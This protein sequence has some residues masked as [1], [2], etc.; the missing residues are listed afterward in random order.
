M[1]KIKFYI[2]FS[3][4]VSLFFTILSP[5]ST[6]Y[7]SVEEAECLPAVLMLR[8]SGEGVVEGEYFQDGQQIFTT[9]PENNRGWE[10]ETIERLLTAFAAQTDVDETTSKVRFIG[11][12][13]TALGLAPVRL[14]DK[15]PGVATQESKATDAIR[16][17]DH[18]IRY[19]D[20]YLDGAEKIMEIIKSD[21]ERPNGESCVTNYMLVGYSQGVISLRL[22]LG[23]YGLSDKITSTYVIGDPVQKANGATSDRQM[24]IANTSPETDGVVRRGIDILQ[25]VP[26]L[27]GLD[28][29]RSIYTSGDEM[30]YQDNGEGGA[31][32]RSLCHEYDPT[33]GIKWGANGDE[34]G[35]YFQADTTPEP[36]ESLAGNVDLLSEI[37]EFD[38]QIRRLANQPTYT[39][40]PRELKHSMAIQGQEVMYTLANARGADKCW[41]DENSDGVI[42]KSD[43]S[44]LDPYK[45]QIS[46]ATAS[47]TVEVVDSFGGEYVFTNVTPTIDP[48]EVKHLGSLN[49]N[50]WYQLHPYGQPNS[51]LTGVHDKNELLTV[52]SEPSIAPCET[53][54]PSGLEQTIETSKQSFKATKYPYAFPTT[55]EGEITWGYDRDWRLEAGYEVRETYENGYYQHLPGPNHGKISIQKYSSYD[56]LEIRLAKIENGIPYYSIAKDNLCAFYD[57]SQELR[58]DLWVTEDSAGSLCS[59]SNDQL[60]SVTKVNAQMGGLS[61]EQD[62]VHPT[63]VTG[64]VASEIHK[65]SVTL[66]WDPASDIRDP[67]V[68]YN[69]YDSDF[70]S[71]YPII[72]KY[73]GTSVAVNRTNAGIEGT[74]YTVRAVDVG[75]NE[76]LG[77]EITLGEPPPAPVIPKPNTPTLGNLAEDYISVTINFPYTTERPVSSV[78]IYKN[79]VFY[80]STSEN[81]ITD[82]DIER[83]NVYEYTYETVDNYGDVSER[84]DILWVSTIND[85]PPSPPSNLAGTVNSAGTE[86]RISFIPGMDDMGDDLIYILYRNGVEIPSTNV[87]NNEI[88]DN[89]AVPG[90]NTYTIVAKDLDGN[91]SIHSEPLEV[92]MVLPDTQAPKKPVLNVT[93]VTNTSVYITIEST[94]NVSTPHFSIYRDGILIQSTDQSLIFD[95]LEPDTTYEYT[96][97]AVDDVGNVSEISDILTVT[98]LDGDTEAPTKPQLTLTETTEST[99]RFSI[100]STDNQAT[101]YY[102]VYRD[103]V[104]VKNVYSNSFYQSGLDAATTYE[105]TV[106][107]KDYN[108]NSSETSDVLTVTTNIPEPVDTEAPSKPIL[109]VG[110]L[111]EYSVSIN[112]ESTDNV[113]IDA[114]HIYR[115]GS[116]QTT[117]Y[118]STYTDNSLYPG[119]SYT[120]EVVAQD[121]SWNSSEMSDSL[122]VTAPAPTVQLPQVENLQN[123]FTAHNVVYFSWSVNEPWKVS[124]YDVYRDGVLIASNVYETSYIDRTVSADTEYSYTIIGKDW[125]NN[126][127]DMSQP[128]VAETLPTPTGTDTLAPSSFEFRYPSYYNDIVY[129]SWTE[130]VDDSSDVTYEV[131]RDGVLLTELENTLFYNN[132]SVSPET[133]YKYSVIAVDAAGNETTIATPCTVLTVNPGGMG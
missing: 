28:A 96:V 111:S 57:S 88:V 110:S 84:S 19:N 6:V 121:M 125:N 132:S 11:V 112:I 97:T 133:S 13:Y 32:S 51:C 9:G 87:S 126:Q 113:G 90:L 79:N 94:D 130:A 99:V 4:V 1:K 68:K 103:G 71:I 123:K 55:P 56:H 104:F 116:Y 74:T 29:L 23:L 14:I 86:V 77:A 21:L 61:L 52:P 114:Y 82:N 7:A 122:T 2:V 25:S 76:G 10:G 15:T 40:A 27:L 115:D 8:G 58:F 20:S 18:I 119:T 26:N 105:Y 59:G 127:T 60:F 62:T 78:N 108:G 42:E 45:T 50:N 36:D 72:E 106:I 46:G 66:S 73:S 65:N 92:N 117:I 102:A 75:G 54:S 39:I 64:L 37:P 49:P 131:Y 53:A 109:T 33:C 67:D 98:T 48:Q 93:E 89:S 31:I 100:S 83:G 69:I 95:S 34:H 3:V 85:N 12:P 44:C 120:Y 70:S 47:M 30:L 22:A 63:A 5:A 17:I 38:K 41:W 101:P 24:S 129:L 43:V 128:L 118:E 35:N 91:S 81:F 124:V 80:S 107:A 16:W